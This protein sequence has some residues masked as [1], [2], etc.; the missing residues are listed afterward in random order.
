MRGAPTSLKTASAK[1]PSIVAWCSAVYD[2][3][4]YPKGFAKLLTGD[5]AKRYAELTVQHT[6]ARNRWY[7]RKTVANRD[8]VNKLVQECKDFLEKE[9][10]LDIRAGAASAKAIHIATGKSTTIAELA[11]QIGALA[12]SQ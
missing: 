12:Q 1:A 9:C 6:T 8:A 10:G 2:V 11:A 4:R 5:R 7:Q 3:K